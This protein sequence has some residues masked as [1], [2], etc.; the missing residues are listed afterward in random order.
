MIRFDF[1]SCV[2]ELFVSVLQNSILGRAQQKGL[3]EVGIH[4]LHDYS[5]DKHRRVDDYP[6][7]GGS[8]MVLQAEPIVRCVRAL[9]AERSYD[10]VLMTDP[11]AQPLDQ[12]MAM[13]LSSLRAI[14]VICGHYQGIDE[15]VQEL[16]LVDRSFS[17]GSYVLTGGELPA[18]VLCD[19]VTRLL[20]GALGDGQSALEDSFQDGLLAPP[21]YTRPATYEGLEVPKV[22]RSGNQ[23]AVAAWREA[24]ALARAKA[25]APKG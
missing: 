12:R 1:I 15:R 4:R 13:R 24:A 9:Q 7:G 19:A 14:I 16:G 5:A 11:C 22:L 18:L 23:E 2:P 6:Y 10:A 20:P 8:G 21:C 3:L 25:A 17:V